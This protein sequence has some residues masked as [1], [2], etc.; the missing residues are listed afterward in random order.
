MAV[1]STTVQTVRRQRFAFALLCLTQFMV[2][3]D[4]SVVNVALPSMQR[5]LGLSTQA[6][7]WVV[8]AYSLT[9]GCFVA[10]WTGGRS[11]WAA[12]VAYG[13]PGALLSRLAYWRLCVKRHLVH[14]CTCY[15]GT[16]RYAGCTNDAFTDCDDLCRRP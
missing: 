11:L 5:D 14:H 12:P 16:R 2:V 15:S 9:F 6:L 8:S 4:A 1:A 3:L 13:G 7:Q 10:Q